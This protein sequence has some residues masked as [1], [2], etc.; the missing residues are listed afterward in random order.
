MSI[1]GDLLAMGIPYCRVNKVDKVGTV[2]CYSY[3]HW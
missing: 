1:S 2:G 3:F